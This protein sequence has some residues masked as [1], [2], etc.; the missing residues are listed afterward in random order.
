MAKPTA[1]INAP[2]NSGAANPAGSARA[3]EKKA[4]ARQT[5][6]VRINNSSRLKRPGRF[7][8]LTGEVSP[9]AMMGE[10]LAVNR[11]QWSRL[12][13]LAAAEKSNAW[14]QGAKNL[15]RRKIVSR[16]GRTGK[17]SRCLG[18]ATDCLHI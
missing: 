6:A 13:L 15:G 7:E 14:F 8:T 3:H 9:L 5:K 10:P 18:I 11:D 2:T 1:P 12:R 17:T 4:P 16:T